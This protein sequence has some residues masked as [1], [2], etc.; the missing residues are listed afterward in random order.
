[1]LKLLIEHNT[2]NLLGVL[3]ILSCVSNVNVIQSEDWYFCFVF[4]I[5]IDEHS[6]ASDYN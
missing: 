3:K 6:S 1:M 5:A 4:T 2:R